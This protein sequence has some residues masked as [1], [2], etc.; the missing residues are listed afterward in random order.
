MRSETWDIVAYPGGRLCLYMHLSPLL[1]HVQNHPYLPFSTAS[2][3]Y[4]HTLSVVVFGL[5]CLLRTTCRSF[6]VDRQSQQVIHHVMRKS[7][8]TFVPINHVVLLLLFIRVA[9]PRILIKVLLLSFSFYCQVMAEFTFL[10][11]FA[12]PLLKINAQHRF[13]IHPERNF[14]RLNWFKK[15][16]SFSPGSFVRGLFLLALILFSIF[17]LLLGSFGGSSLRL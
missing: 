10:P 16:S 2:M 11:L 9:F 12:D 5:P 14:L 15:C 13:W 1:G 17:L 3:K 7:V 8:Q 6:S 4:L